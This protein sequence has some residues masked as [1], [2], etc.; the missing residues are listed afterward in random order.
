M[1]SDRVA[2]DCV[3]CAKSSKYRIGRICA[4]CF[5]RIKVSLGSLP[6]L[7]GEAAGRLEMSSVGGRS[8]RSAPGSRPP[9]NLDAV[10]P[11]LGLIDLN[12]GD[13][14]SRVTILEAL[15]SWERI[16]RDRNN[17]APYGVATERNRD[18]LSTT[19][20]LGNVCR[21]LSVWLEWIAEDEDTDVA[22]FNQHVS[23]SRRVLLRWSWEGDPPPRW[24]VAC[25]TVRSEGECGTMLSFVGLEDDE[26]R[27]RACGSRWSPARLLA[28]ATSVDAS[29]VWVDAEAAGVAVGVDASTVRRWA[30]SGRVR[31]QGQRYSL[32]DL[33]ACAASGG[34]ASSAVV[35]EGSSGA[36]GPSAVVLRFPGGGPAQ[37][38]D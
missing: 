16:V 23:A 14:S 9:I 38:G 11:A 19:A 17:L 35:L 30:R 29:S 33:K 5:S 25:P 4:T 27:C 24:R 6:H 12:P 10:D 28:V 32:G 15:E 18:P 1:G 37:V 31:R 3:I 7:A 36:A 22:E 2:A 21:F 26:V 8:G 20:V 13:P 34:R